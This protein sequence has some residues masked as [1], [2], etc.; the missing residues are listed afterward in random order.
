MVLYRTITH[1]GDHC[2]DTKRDPIVD[3]NFD[4]LNLA[5]GDVRNGEARGQ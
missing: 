5:F 4:I 2:L 1:K 3:T